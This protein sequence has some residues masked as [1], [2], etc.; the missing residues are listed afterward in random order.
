MPL[1]IKVG[2]KATATLKE[3]DGPNGTGNEVPPIG[4]VSYM[5]DNPSVAT[6]DAATGS[7]TG[8]AP[9]T[10]N[11]TGTDGGNSLSASDVLTVEAVAQS[12]TLS[13]AAA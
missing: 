12:A 5:S 11:L 13:L 10:A 7:I 6:V 2:G 1:T 8:V 9:G 4:P 3:W